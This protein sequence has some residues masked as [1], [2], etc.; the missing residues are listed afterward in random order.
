[1]IL[2]AL[3]YMVSYADRQSLLILVEPVKRELLLSD[4]QVGLLGGFS[5][6]LFYTLAGVP[7]AWIADRWH[8]VRIVS[9]SCQSACSFR[10]PTMFNSQRRRRCVDADLEARSCGGAGIA[11]DA[12]PQPLG[13]LAFY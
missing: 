4:A 5:F 7:I 8:G 13:E 1:L 9:W 12:N 2:L 10:E 6:A 11:R 3:V